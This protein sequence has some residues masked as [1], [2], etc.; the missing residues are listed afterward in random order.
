MPIS[1]GA[2]W[3]P[4]GIGARSMTLPKK[5]ISSSSAI[6]GVRGGCS[7]TQAAPLAAAWA[8][9]SDCSSDVAPKMVTAS[10]MRP[11]RSSRPLDD[12][13][14]FRRR[15]L[16]TSVARPSTA[17]P[18]PPPATQISAWRRIAARSSVSRAVK[19]A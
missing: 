7:T 3:M 11:A 17:M 9:A 2:F 14:P 15:E 8:T 6:P 18:W 13:A 19:K 5:R 12:L 4:A 16:A 10:G 1:S